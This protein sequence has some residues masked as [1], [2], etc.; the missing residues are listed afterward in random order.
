M[1][2]SSH[3]IIQ[4]DPDKLAVP[5][6]RIMSQQQKQIMLHEKQMQVSISRKND[7]PL[8]EQCALVENLC[9]AHSSSQPFLRVL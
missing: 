5:R 3:L 6:E 1:E 7:R 9:A 4:S 8:Y 2:R